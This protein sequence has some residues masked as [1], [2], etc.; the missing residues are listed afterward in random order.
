MNCPALTEMLATSPV[1]FL[2]I[3]A[4]KFPVHFRALEDL[5]V[6]RE[7]YTTWIAVRVALYLC[8]NSS[9]L[10]VALQSVKTPGSRKTLVDIPA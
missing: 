3:P 7:T 1:E 2:N 6:A 10:Q 4:G 9:A 5:A 8:L